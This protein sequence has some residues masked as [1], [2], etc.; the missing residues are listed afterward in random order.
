MYNGKKYYRGSISVASVMAPSLIEA[1]T[2][3]VIGNDHIRDSVKDKLDVLCVSS[4]GHVTV[5]LLGCGFVLGL[6]LSLDIGGSFA[7]LLSSCNNYN[8]LLLTSSK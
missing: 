1:T 5:N 7:I 3:E 4:T 6:K 8:V 2:S